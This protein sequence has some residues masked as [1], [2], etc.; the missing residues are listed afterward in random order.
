MTELQQ[1]ALSL[2]GSLIPY[3]REQL[4]AIKP[5]YFTYITCIQ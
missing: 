3:E 1:T 5:T 2:L 4:N